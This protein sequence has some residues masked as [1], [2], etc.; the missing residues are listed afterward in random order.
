[1][2][3][4]FE[5]NLPLVSLMVFPELVIA[6]KPYGLFTCHLQLSNSPYSGNS[7]WGRAGITSE[8]CVS[9]VYEGPGRAAS[10][11]LRRVGLRPSRV[12]WITLD[13]KRPFHLCL[14]A[15]PVLSGAPCKLQ[16]SSSGARSLRTTVQSTCQPELKDGRAAAVDNAVV[17]RAPRGA[18]QSTPTRPHLNT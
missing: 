1:M 17:R 18:A 12:A 5:D 8:N 4:G 6:Q 16:I 13:P 15:G 7:W 9:G 2:S 3:S 10:R 14:I 11:K